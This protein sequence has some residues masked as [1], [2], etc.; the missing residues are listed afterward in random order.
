MLTLP[1]HP[2]AEWKANAILPLGFIN[3]KYRHAAKSTGILLEKIHHL[4][5]GQACSEAYLYD[6]SLSVHR[7]LGQQ[8]L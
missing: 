7:T 6:P 4:A 2:L 8:A 3:P 1:I 5:L